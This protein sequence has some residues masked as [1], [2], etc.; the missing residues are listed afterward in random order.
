VVEALVWGFVASVSLL[1]GAWVALRLHPS[2]TVISLTMA[3][4]AGALISAVAYELVL[5]SVESGH[6]IKVVVGL[7]LGS[8][9]FTIGDRAIE[10][11]G[12]ARDSGST[13]GQAEGS[14][15]AIVL[16][17]VLDGIP[18]SLVLGLSVAIGGQVS[19]SFVVATFLSNMPEGI[20]A[21]SG[22]DGAG[23]APA[24]IYR[25]W[26]LVVAA[27]VVS[28]GIGYVVFSASAA[29]GASVQAFAA[30]AILTM[31]ADS[32]M[33]QAF[34][35]GGPKVGVATVAGFVVALAVASL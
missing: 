5:E 19:A 25:L 23:W 1:L 3:F 34:E 22:L 6:G 4:G 18:E 14:P 8:I 11:M 9:A 10:R 15:L 2:R 21:S 20:A 16:G 12:G 28:V 27:S 24:R 13:G 26:A 35:M 30:G 33:P 31:L 7:F 32:L 17:A 29:T